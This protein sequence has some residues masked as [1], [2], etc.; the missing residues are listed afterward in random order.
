MVGWLGHLVGVIACW[1]KKSA[2]SATTRGSRVETR[3]G[4]YYLT[5]QLNNGDMSKVHKAVDTVQQPVVA[6]KLMPEAL[7]QGPVFRMRMQ[8]KAR[9]PDRLQ[10]PHVVPIYDY[11]ETD[12]QL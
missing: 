1:L 5:R 10:E 4:P 9:N 2:T 6:L 11:D 3:F 7:S 8:R 12:G